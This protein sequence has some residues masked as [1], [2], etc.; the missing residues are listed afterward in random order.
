MT[1]MLQTGLDV[2]P[3]ITHQ[4]GVEQY[5]DAFDVLASGECGKVIIDWS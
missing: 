3:V 4:F 5:Q 1:T 2:S